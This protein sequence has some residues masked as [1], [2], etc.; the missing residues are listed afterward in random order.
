MLLRAR[1][2]FV[3]CLSSRDYR[4]HVLWVRLCEPGL[5]I[6]AC[7]MYYNSFPNYR[8]I[9]QMRIRGPIIMTG[10]ELWSRPLL[11]S[12]GRGSTSHQGRFGFSR[13]QSILSS[14]GSRCILRWATFC[15]GLISCWLCSMSSRYLLPLF[16][17]RFLSWRWTWRRACSI[18][19]SSPTWLIYIRYWEISW[20]DREN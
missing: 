13:L 5:M 6:K 10:K 4:R 18:A 1:I 12:K 3:G 7:L 16:F 20:M 19:S 17:R 14:G 9:C 2:F 8:R 15:I 11:T